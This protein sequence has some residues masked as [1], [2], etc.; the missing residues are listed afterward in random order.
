MR[1]QLTIISGNQQGLTTDFNQEVVT[2]GRSSGNDLTIDE[3]HVSGVH[4]KF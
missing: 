3:P 2:I 1:F 4:A